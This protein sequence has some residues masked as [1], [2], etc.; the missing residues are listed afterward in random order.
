MGDLAMESDVNHKFENWELDK[1]N[2]LPLE[3]AA[4]ATK[5][6]PVDERIGEINNQCS[7]LT[8][9]VSVLHSRLTV[10]LREDSDNVGDPKTSP[11]YPT[12]LENNLYAI[13]ERLSIQIGALERMVSRISL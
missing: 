13:E 10:I 11:E 7:R 12:V 8:E 2:D 9:M 5:R 3:R 4:M 1:M 6:S